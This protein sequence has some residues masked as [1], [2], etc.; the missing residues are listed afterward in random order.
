MRTLFLRALRNIA[1]D[2]A[3]RA[4]VLKE[5]LKTR[6]GEA[7]E[8]ALGRAVRHLG[9]DYAQYAAIIAEVRE[10]GRLHGTDLRDAAHAL[11]NQ[12]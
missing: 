6:H 5:A 10:Y 9:G 12:T 3:A 2:P 11:A 4:R 1:M 8:K 7:F